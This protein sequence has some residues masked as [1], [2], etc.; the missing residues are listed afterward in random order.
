MCCNQKRPMCF[1]CFITG[2][3]VTECRFCECQPQECVFDWN[4]FTVFFFFSLQKN[5]SE[6]Q[7]LIS[8]SVSL[9]SAT[10]LSRST[11]INLTISSCRCTNSSSSSTNS[12]W[13]V[14]HEHDSGCSCALAFALATA[15]PTPL[16]HLTGKQKPTTAK[17]R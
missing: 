3:H 5:Y 13:I 1:S 14:A 7:Y 8:S 15:I 16:Q 6:S 10:S 4:S 9:I 17:K 11:C 12:V 2:A